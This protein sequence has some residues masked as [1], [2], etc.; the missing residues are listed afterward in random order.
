MKLRKL[1]N[2]VVHCKSREEYDRLMTIYEEAGWKWRGGEKPTEFEGWAG[3]SRAEECGLSVDAYDDFRCSN[4]DWMSK[5]HPEK[6][7]RS[8]SEFIFEQGIHVTVTETRSF[9]KKYT[10]FQHDD[11]PFA[12]WE[13]DGTVQLRQGRRKAKSFTV[14]GDLDQWVSAFFDGYLSAPT[15]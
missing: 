15:K 11:V 14:T 7:T 12:L 8:L 4:S 3:T 1:P 9:L 5:N 2:T 10:V 6:K 13:R